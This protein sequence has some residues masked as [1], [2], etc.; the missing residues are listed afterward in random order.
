LDSYDIERRPVAFQRLLLTHAVFWAEASTAPLPSWLRRVAAPA[1]APLLPLLMGRRRLVAQA[2]RQLSQLGIRYRRSPLSVQG[3]DAHGG[4][5]R[6]RAGDRVPDAAVI[7][8]G[9]PQRMHDLLAGPGVHLFLHRD[10]PPL[11]DQFG[12]HVSVHRLNSTP[13]SGL[14]AVRPDGYA[15]LRCSAIDPETLGRWL[16]LTGLSCDRSRHA[17]RPQGPT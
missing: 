13:G 11:T 1:A 9:R 10:A 8:D 14:L 16:T 3:P 5:G 2:V 7:A 4:C 15:G 17:P 6:P 12:P